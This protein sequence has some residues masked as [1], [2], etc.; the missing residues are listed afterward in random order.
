MNGL[1]C[2]GGLQLSGHVRTWIMILQ[3]D[4]DDDH[5]NHNGNDEVWSSIE[6][7]I[8]NCVSLSLERIS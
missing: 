2:D 8:Q 6:Q 7:T 3:E 1:I 4:Q 5:K